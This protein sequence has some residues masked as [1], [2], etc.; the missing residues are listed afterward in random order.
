MKSIKKIT[1]LLQNSSKKCDE[2]V[3]K[4]DMRRASGDLSGK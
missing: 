2:Q 4:A 3:A 1:V